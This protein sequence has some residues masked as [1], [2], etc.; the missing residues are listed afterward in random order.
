MSF[1]DQYNALKKKREEDKK[2]KKTSSFEEQYAQLKA[3][4][5]DQPIT[6]PSPLGKDKIFSSGLNLPTK[7]EEKRT[8]FQSGAFEDG[9]QFG[10][11]TK[12]ILGSVTDVREN[13]GA[14]ILGIGEKVVDAG[15]YVVGGIGGLLGADEFTE[16][17][18]EFIAKDLY[19]EKKIAQKIIGIDTW[20]QKMVGI[21]SND[22]VLGDKTDALVQSGGQLLGTMGLQAVG[23][24]WFVTSG[25]TSFGGEV[26]NAFNQ[27]A[28]YGEAGLSGVVAAGAEMLSEKLFGG[29]G[30]GEK[31][32]VNLDGLTKG[33]SSK[34]W[35][36]LADFGVDMAAEGMEEVFSEMAGNLGSALYKEESLG[37]LLFSEEA[38]DGYIES[39]ISGAAL[40]GFA[41]VGK[42]SNSVATG[43]DYRS[44]MTDNEQKVF[45]K[46]YEDR[47]AEAEK[48]GKL[49]K[50][51]KAK[52]YDQVLEDMEKG[53]ISTDTIESV[54]GDKSSYDALSKEA[55][56]FKTLYETEGG[57]LSEKQ[58]DRLAELKEKNKVTPYDT[59]LKTEKD[60]FSQSVF[61]MVQG[62]KLAESYYERAKAGQKF[63]ADLSKYDTKQQETVKKAMESGVLNNTRRTHELV[64]LVAKITADKGVLFDFTSN[65]KLKD[66]GFSVDGKVVNGYFDKKSNAIGVN[67][68]SSK[69]LNTVVGHEITHVLEGTEVYDAL[70]QTLFEYAKRKGEYQSRYDSLAKMYKNIKDADVEAELAADLVGDYLFTDPDFIHSLS[71]ENKNLF[72]KIWDEIKYLAKVVTGTKEAREL[73]KVKRAFE[74]AYKGEGKAKGTK[75]SISETT[76][77]R[78]VAVVDSD[79]LSNIDTSTWDKTKKAEAKKAASKALKEFS[80]GI[81]VDGITRKV[82]RVSIREYTRS[83]YTES[84]YNQAPDV[85]ADKMRAAEVADDIV[86]AATNWNRDGGLK[87][88]RS[89]NFVD[90]DHGK[91]LILSGDAK[92]IAE[93]VVGITNA[94]EAVFYD[95]VD[96]QPA[97]FDI[98]KAESPTTATTQNA[99]GDIQGDS[100]RE[101]I[102]Q[103]GE[104]VKY[105]LSDSDG[106]ELTKEQREY[107][108]DSKMRD[109]EGNLKVMYH[110]SRDAGFHVFDPSRSDDGTSLFF[111]DRNDVAASYSGT[112]E[113]YE[114]KTIRTAEDMN[115][116][117]AEI[118]YDQY[119]AVEKDGRFELLEDGD[120]VA[121]S[122]TAQGIYEEFCWYEGVG[123]G[124][125]NYKVYLNLTNPLEVD[126]GGR[127]WNNISREYS[128]EIADRYKTLT[129]EEKAALTD[130]AEWGEYGIFKDEMLNARALAERGEA[131]VFDEAY[132]RNLASAY[133]KLGGANANLYDAFS[134]AQDNFSEEAINQFAV[135]QMNTRDYAKKAKEEGYDGVIF[136]NIVDVGGYGGEYT[137]ST[138]AIAFDSNQVKSVAN[139]KPTADRDI[140]YSVSEAQNQKGLTNEQEV[141]YSISNDTKYAD[142][143]IKLNQK[144]KFVLEEV[145]QAQKIMRERV[146]D[147]LKQMMEKGVALPEDIEGNTYIANS[148]YDGTEENTTICPRSLASEAFVDAVSEYL[149][150]PLTVEE[151][152]YISQDLQGRSMTPECTYCYVATDRKAYRAF[153]GEYI[154]QRDAVLEKLKANPNADVSRSGEMYQDFLDGRKDTNPMYKRFK[155]WVDAYTNGT[156]MVQASHLANINKLM[157]D[158]NEFGAE[159]KPQIADAMKYA[160]SA[161]WAKKRVNYVAYNGHI[162]N[163]KQD[164]INKLN[165]HYG[166]RM[167]SFSDFHPAFVLENMQ[168]ITDASVKGLKMLGYTKDT[169]FVD[170]FAPTGMNINVS[171]FGFESGGNVYENNIIGAEW[172]KAQELRAQYPNVGV[173]FV[174]TNDTMVNWALE[175][176][177][178]DVVIPYHLVRTGAEVAKAFGYTN[179]T[180]ESADTK[181][182]EWA[183]G[184]KKSIAPT[185]HNNDKVTYLDALQKN[186]LNPRFARFMDNPNYMKLVNEC[187]QSASESEPVQPVF[188]EEAID[189]TLAKLEANGY[190]QPIGGSVERMYEIAAEVAE[191]MTQELAPAM[192][193]SDIGQEQKRYG[194]WNVYGKDIRYTPDIAPVAETKNA[195][196]VAKNDTS[197]I[198][199]DAREL[200]PD[201]LAP[202][203]DFDERFDSITDE[204]APP[205]MEAPYYQRDNMAVSDPFQDRDWYDIGNRKV[206]AY[207]YENP[208][209]KPFFQEE[210]QNLL[211]E[212]SDTVRGERWYNDELYYE[213]GGEK[214]FGGVSRMT[215][216]SMEELL[217][218]WHMSYADIEKGLNAIIE[219]HGAENIAAAKKLE[220]MLNDRLLNG[221]KSFYTGQMVEPNDAY[222]QLLYEKQINSY[223]KE[224][225]DAFMKT[226]DQYAP[227]DD[228]APVAKAEDIAPVEAKTTKGGEVAG[229]KAMYK[230]AVQGES[231]K[232]AKILFEGQQTKKQKSAWKW[233]REHIFSK[234][235][236]FEDMALKTGNRELQAKF[237]N[238]RR[239]ESRAQTFMG[240]GKWNAKALVDVRKTVED[241]GKIEDFNYYLYHMHNVDR[242]TLEERFKDVPN[243]SVFGDGVDAEVSRKAAMNLETMN[244][245]F[246]EW[247]EDVYDINRHLRQMMV[248]EGIISQETADLW[249]TMYPHYVPISRAGVNGLNVNI[250]LDT[251]RTGVNAPIKKAEGGNSDFYNVFDTMGSRIEQ[252]YKA[253]AK[254]RFGVELMNT[255]GTQFE[256]EQADIDSVLENMDQH[257]E[258]LQEGKNG[259]SPSFTVFQN[260]ERVKFAITEDMYDAM[261]PSQFTYTN[262]V[263]RKINDIRRDILTTYSP[264]FALTNP[265]KDMQDIL[266]NSQHP[267]KTYA[268]IPEAIYS[269]IH[270]DQWY[271]ER[272]EN[273]GA[274]DSYFDGQTKTFK[275]E[276]VGFKKV[277]GWLPGK[278]Q[279]VNE[280]IEQV[281]RMAEYIASRKMGRSIDVSMLDAARVTT[282]FGAAGDLTNMLNRNGFTFLGASVEGFNQ[283]FRN[284]REAKAEGAKGW[285]KL[286]GKTLV[287]GLPALLL[288]HLLWDDDE[289]YSELSDYVKQNYYVIAKT[290]DGKF[291]RIP[292][293]RAV[294]VI[295]DAFQQM[296]NLITGNDQVD[297]DSFA[298]LVINNLAPNNPLENNLLAPVY[299]ALTNKTWYGDDLVPTRLQKVPAAEQ[300]DETTDSLSKWLGDVT[301]TSPYK[302]NYLLDQYSGGIGDMIL[303]Y[304][305]TEADGGGLGAALRDKFVTDPVLK[306]QNVTDFYDTMDD[307]TQNANSMYATDEDVLM[308]KYMSS[309]NSQL[310]ELYQKKREIQ[311]SDLSDAEKYTQVRDIQRQIVELTREGLKTYGDVSI[312]G[313]YA[314]VG[315][316]HF[317]QNKGEWQKITDKQLEKQEEV[318]KGLGITPSE[319]WSDKDTYDFMYEYPDKYQFLKENGVSYEDYANG[320]E[321][322]KDAWTWA[323]KNPEKFVVG[324]AVAGDVVTYRKY[325]GELYDIK[326]DKDEYGQSISGS[327]KEKVIDYI[328]GMDLDYGQKIILFKSEYEADDS[329]NYDII[330]YLNGREDI[331]YSEMETILK[332][333]G[334]RVDSEGNITW[335]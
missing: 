178:I 208:E 323:S 150:R 197:T 160:Q 306:N 203:D 212:L 69:Y 260:G 31:G 204:D 149:G 218:S 63:E 195:A 239:A 199:A 317:R 139:E 248:D 141:T 65:E 233:A 196:E 3:E 224:A 266:L 29:S 321:E 330:E 12:T 172:A 262:E 316:V 82:N 84:L 51:E 211:G 251:K 304:L 324:K 313:V 271:Q 152:I 161:S 26:E 72:Q 277:V 78:F 10:D 186:H 83:N 76:D 25:T 164:R 46:V 102:A 169:D 188:N 15:A 295:Q 17:T 86:V 312:D 66:S 298:Q 267:G 40:G 71:T 331:S 185:E 245:E 221:Y 190:Y 75:Y 18:K 159:L 279:A 157:G 226:A 30:L 329:Y 237:D 42:V 236:V 229:Q 174:A 228:I 88:P 155:M 213:S 36:A 23:V 38:I 70:K 148:S 181:T 246:K 265:I 28:S 55:E 273:G 44:G 119:E 276:D 207:M 217:D 235:A 48:N 100:S 287:A 270:K 80:G 129:A 327:R 269:M 5:E 307:L 101:N 74:K 193:I 299:Q 326:A 303:P 308:N 261:K 259:E 117:L 173:T 302:W 64:D 202:M 96:M 105:S 167:Y 4:T 73:E 291:I 220:F 114:A 249:Q 140:R 2:K 255:L 311:N 153:L 89:D 20:S 198:P 244:P 184:D 318:T 168:M 183:K 268:S 335:D 60:K 98:K 189:R 7:K 182:K 214:G 112:I 230:E 130:L 191:G 170:I 238:I 284:I 194:R 8:W 256:S 258:L 301:D 210:A 292:K 176:D 132:T 50:D 300:F 131:G 91:T 325:T 290:E 205:E 305:T 103:E 111:V 122:D 104:N 37:D 118:G 222:I 227:Q 314:T 136:K 264:T 45:D 59:L 145:M 14:G 315:N 180:S 163:W 137:H 143:A 57:K 108:K 47:V 68:D 24:P 282:N 162:L 41:N 252:T 200:F 216:E 53:Y 209:V 334:F 285:A 43:K 206:K 95:V 61:G 154:K 156:P 58:R 97:I 6:L 13:L 94:G 62:E 158:I 328:N 283:Q 56:E 81:V 93:V 263:L 247:A 179:Y 67:V 165:S 106:K 286:A 175:Q 310:S 39:F 126:A 320:S 87:H 275:K 116:F 109:E 19:D 123:E 253:I 281:P 333:L 54:L 297:I 225:F 219:D 125:A 11:V 146:A 231:D 288:N 289:D 27:G 144:N 294:A 115:N 32:L 49:T 243:K 33:I 16:K 215:S 120:H 309:I 241:A 250:P 187:R 110:G 142:S 234:G 35:K 278:I 21:D 1:T 171:T 274:Q 223:S 85:F 332:E 151:Q 34:L 242:M 177:W 77:G 254:N 9:Y 280:V 113:T 135:K 319:Y 201:D 232:V 322:F 134:I 121:W 107:F 133:E 92:Y 124:D 90:F 192:S 52:I 22:S 293:G 99:I 79:I 240:K 147:R 272:M 127:N 138:V 128:Q 296:E 166:L 257:E